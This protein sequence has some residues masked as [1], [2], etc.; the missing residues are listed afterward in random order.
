V[1]KD[2]H[3]KLLGAIATFE[4]LE[5]QV[6]ENQRGEIPAGD[7]K[8]LVAQVASVDTVFPGLLPAFDETYFRGRIAAQFGLYD[9][10]LIKN[11][12]AVALAAL[13]AA[14]ENSTSD[15]VAAAAG[16]PP[17]NVSFVAAADLRAILERDS[18]EI[19]R[20]YAHSCWKSVIILCG[21]FMEALLI[22]AITK[23]LAAQSDP[24]AANPPSVNNMRLVN[25]I[26][27]AFELN[28]VSKGVKDLSNTLR[29][30]R[31][32][33][34]AS[35]ELRDKLR[36]DQEEARVAIAILAIVKRDLA[37]QPR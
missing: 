34:H 7:F 8:I 11:W 33:V 4:T 25:L 13:R 1:L 10:K 18:A 32:L 27:K 15:P 3:N 6:S 2:E 36:V 9:A 30:Y 21:G 14:R 37:A 26:Q 22:D 17:L 28:L 35:A 23:T 29:E 16:I 19:E 31:N 5:K 24:P 12:L 20:A